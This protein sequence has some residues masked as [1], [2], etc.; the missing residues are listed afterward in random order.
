MEFLS[1]VSIVFGH[2]TNAK[3]HSKLYHCPGL[4]LSWFTIVMVY[5]CPGLPLSWFTIV[6][7]YHCPGLP[8]SLFTIVLV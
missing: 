1:L 4:P 2:K 5:H 8:L 6:M 7:V 3:V